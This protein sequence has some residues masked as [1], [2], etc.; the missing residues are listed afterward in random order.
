MGE[1]T[2][3]FIDDHPVLLEGIGK[4]FSMDR[5]FRVVASGSSAS[6]AIHISRQFRPDVLVM[7]LNMEGNAFEAIGWIARAAPET[8]V[9]AFTAASGTDAAVKALEAGASGYVF[10][11]STTEELRRAIFAVLK[12]GTFISQEVA[13]SVITA[14]RS[15]KKGHDLDRNALKLSVREQQVVSFLLLGKT[16]REIAAE[17]GIGDK[18]VKHYI[19][20]LLQKLQVRN[21]TELVLAAQRLPHVTASPIGDYL[22]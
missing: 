5:A 20:I 19:G 10:K 22:N 4:I 18:T 14:L 12:G 11:G 6:D 3:A 7:D 21:R 9:V 8:K 1:V 13:L 16:N 2:L 17:L 15:S